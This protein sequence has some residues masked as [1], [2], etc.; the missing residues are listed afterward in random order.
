MGVARCFPGHAS[1]AEPLRS[2]EGG[3]FEPPVI[4]A[5]S[6]G[7][8]EFEKKFPIIGAIKRGGNL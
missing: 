4:E 3:A 2:I 8:A 6:L 7:L 1:E 5:K